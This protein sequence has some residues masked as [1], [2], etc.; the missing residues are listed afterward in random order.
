MTAISREDAIDAEYETL[1]P[2]ATRANFPQS[3]AFAASTHDLPVR[4]A[5]LDLL[6]R[7]LNDHPEGDHPDALTLPFLSLTLIAALVVFWVSGGHALLY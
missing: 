7:V 1:A 6:R 2:A 4:D 5:Q 3:P